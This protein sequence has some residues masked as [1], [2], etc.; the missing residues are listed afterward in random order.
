MKV[1]ASDYDGTFNHN[2]INDAKIAAVALWRKSGNL[3]GIISGRGYPSL[4]DCIKSH[5][6][7]YDFLVCNNGGVIYNT[8]GEIMFEAR[9]DGAN[10]RPFIEDLFLWGCPMA[11]IDMAEPIRIVN[12]TDPIDDDEIYFSDLPD[13]DYFN[14]ISTELETVEDAAD[15]V[16]KIEEKY[17]HILTPLQNG[18]CIDIVPVGIN[19]AQGLYELLKVVGASYDDIIAVGDDINDTHMIAE[20]RSYAMEN[21]VDSIKELAN[22]NIVSDITEVFN[23]EI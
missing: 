12:T 11:H 9:C 8:D 13:I 3:F 20:F 1:I 16:K 7:E 15:V 18:N 22:H 2:G 14:Q 4:T 19:K 21:A 23:K 6:F 5:P 10:A 17:S